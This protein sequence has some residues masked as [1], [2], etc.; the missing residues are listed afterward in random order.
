L[1]DA[2]SVNNKFWVFAAGTTTLEVKL[3]IKD[4]RLASAWRWG[5]Y[6][7]TGP[8]TSVRT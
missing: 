6:A 4:R 8:W 3:V 5:P 7:S 1:L 2:C